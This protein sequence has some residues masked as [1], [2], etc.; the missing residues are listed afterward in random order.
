MRPVTA[1]DIGYWCSELEDKRDPKAPNGYI[2]RVPD[3]FDGMK[4]LVEGAI[5]NLTAAGKTLFFQ[6][7]LTKLGRTYYLNFP[8]E[9]EPSLRR[10]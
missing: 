3:C 1:C 8:E 7:D 2:V 6:V 5:K 4:L 10:L 9:G